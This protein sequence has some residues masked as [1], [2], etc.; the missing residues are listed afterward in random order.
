ME[1]ESEASKSK[2]QKMDEGDEQPTPEIDVRLIEKVNIK[3]LNRILANAD[4]ERIPEYDGDEV[5]G[6][7]RQDAEERDSK[8]EFVEKHP[9]KSGHIVSNNHVF[10]LPGHADSISHMSISHTE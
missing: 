10:L 3:R 4:K 1:P 5:D 8:I 2:Q 9:P 7:A 6:K